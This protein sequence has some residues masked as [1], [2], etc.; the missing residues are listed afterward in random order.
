MI[1]GLLPEPPCMYRLCALIA[2]LAC[3]SAAAAPADVPRY[4]LVIASFQ[5]RDMAEQ[6]ISRS[7]TEIGE[8][9]EIVVAIAADRSDLYRVAAGPFDSRDV[10]NDRGASL[11]HAFPDA[12]VVAASRPDIGYSSWEE[13]EAADDETQV[14]SPP[15]QAPLRVDEKRKTRFNRL[16]RDL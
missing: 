14:V 5:Q 15:Q 4:W 2:L 13:P 12:W 3:A 1:I 7:A 10:A 9:V 8:P 11:R 6:F 16:Y